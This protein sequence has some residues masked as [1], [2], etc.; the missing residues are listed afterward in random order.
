MRMQYGTIGDSRG[1]V[2]I[3]LRR[4]IKD[5]YNIFF[6]QKKTITAPPPQSQKFTSKFPFSS[7]ISLYFYVIL[8]EGG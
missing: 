5:F 3:F 2:D 6:M 4:G 1:I 7:F 8:P